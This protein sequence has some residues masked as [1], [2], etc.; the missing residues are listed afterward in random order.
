MTVEEG[1]EFSRPVVITDLT[2]GEIRVDAKADE[3]AALA[4]RLG[5]LALD[6][7]DATIHLAAKE[8]GGVRLRGT[9]RAKVTQSCV[10]TLEPLHST[11]KATFERHYAPAEKTGTA[12]EEDLA[13][14][15]EEPPEPLLGDT[16]DLGEAVAEQLAL[17]IDP[18]PRSPGATFNGYVSDKADSGGEAAPSGPFAALAEF[19]KLKRESE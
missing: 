4:R 16:I 9:L 12:A 2:G 8:G 17:E 5:L 11:V 1:P 7:L 13:L 6:S 19:K 14:D 18:F 15:G 3:R 10:V